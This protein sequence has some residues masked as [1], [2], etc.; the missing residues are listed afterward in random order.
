MRLLG[1]K[2]NASDGAKTEAAGGWKVLRI[3]CDFES[4]D[5]SYHALLAE[6]WQRKQR[7]EK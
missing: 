1:L 7:M 5:G 4:D 3:V 6:L 2:K